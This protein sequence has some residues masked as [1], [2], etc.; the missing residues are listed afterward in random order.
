MSEAMGK[1]LHGKYCDIARINNEKRYNIHAWRHSC[2]ISFLLSGKDIYYVK[3]WPGHK[4][5]KSALDYAEIAP[6]EW[7][8]MSKDTVE[9]VFEI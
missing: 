2:A 6:P 3:S 7:R 8:K 1:K 4:S 9:S 5:L